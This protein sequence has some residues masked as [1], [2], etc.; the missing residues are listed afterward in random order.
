MNG[1]LRVWGLL[2]PRTSNSSLGTSSSPK[3]RGFFVGG[4]CKTKSADDIRFL[5]DRD[6]TLDGNL[7]DHLADL[8]LGNI[9]GEYIADR[10][11]KITDA[12]CRAELK[13]FLPKE[14]YE[15]LEKADFQPL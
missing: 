14:T 10:I 15:S 6:A 9:D 1:C 5:L 12:L 2:T 8:L 7:H 3:R 11:A 13:G 4:V